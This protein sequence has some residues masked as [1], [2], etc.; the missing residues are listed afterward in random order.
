MTAFIMFAV[1]LAASCVGAVAGY[2]GGVIIKPVLD[3][4]HILPVSTISF[5][6]GCTVLCMSVASLLRSRGNGVKL[7]IPTTAPLAVGAAAGGLVGK[8]LFE[9]VKANANEDVLGAVQSVVLLATTVLVFFY[10]LK[11]DKLPSYRLTGAGVC[12]FAGGMLGVVSAFL[13][14]GG[15]PLNMALLFF[16]F[17]MEAKEAAKNSLFIIMLSQAASLLSALI[18]G[19]MPGFAWPQL[20]LMALGGV[21]GALLGAGL[22]KR[23]DNKA[24]EKL[25]LALMLV[26][27]LLNACNT[28]AY[29][30]A[31]LGLQTKKT[32]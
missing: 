29:G 21:G 25:L 26:I 12:L 15:G 13:G 9:L 2:G 1:C 28:A 31:A 17:S 5:L 6:S 7:H 23:M 16:F 22:A 4:L 10:T 11:K 8:W 18:Q 14:I 27:I 3:A 24:V 32:Y 20:A 30:M 19:N